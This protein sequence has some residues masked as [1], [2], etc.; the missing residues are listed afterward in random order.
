MAP[1]MDSIGTIPMNNLTD[2]EILLL[3]YQQLQNLSDEFR[4]DKAAKDIQLHDLDNRINKIERMLGTSESLKTAAD[5]RAKK[6]LQ[7][8]GL[9]ITVA[10]I[11]IG[12]LLAIFFK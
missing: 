4:A 9:I 3:A 8:I 1:R 6:Q 12:I 7:W 2:R 11:A 5:A 10:N